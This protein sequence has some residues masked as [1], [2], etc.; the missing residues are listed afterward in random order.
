MEK[1][2]RGLC[3]R[4]RAINSPLGH[5][6]KR[7]GFSGLP[8]AASKRRQTISIVCWGALG[9]GGSRA[10]QG[11]LGGCG[12]PLEMALNPNGGE[13]DKPRVAAKNR[14]ATPILVAGT[15]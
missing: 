12:P 2:I 6:R 8:I 14:T 11:V 10:S 7:R 9:I 13:A 3:P 1:A 4:M 15:L 5:P